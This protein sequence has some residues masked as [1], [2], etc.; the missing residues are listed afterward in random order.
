MNV[1]LDIETIP[2]QRPKAME[3]YREQARTEFHAPS[4]MTK[5]DMIKELA[6]EGIEFPDN[7]KFI[8]AA[9]MKQRWEYHFRD[10][11]AESFAD[12]LYRKTSLTDDCTICVIAIKQQSSK[13]AYTTSGVFSI[14]DQDEYSMLM[15]F[16]DVIQRLAPQGVFFIGHNI[17][18]D[19]ERLQ[20]KYWEHG[21]N[22]HFSLPFDGRHTYDFYDTMQAWAGFKQRVSL[23]NLCSRLGV[24]CKTDIDGAMVWDTWQKEP[25][26]VAAYCLEDVNATLSVYE[27]LTYQNQEA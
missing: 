27:R 13:T 9:E 10:A 12:D 24:A 3:L 14:V 1:V 18:W 20:H 21:L 5:A 19:L 4:K 23:P 7:G 15:K 26:R 22:P 16:A 2:D 8:A 6:A 11:R 17:A 25:E